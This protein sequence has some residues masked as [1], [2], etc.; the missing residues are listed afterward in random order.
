MRAKEGWE[1]I[2]EKPADILEREIAPGERSYGQQIFSYEH[3][4][5]II[6]F[7]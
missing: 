2:E 7:K 1:Y 5:K 4:G 3:Q 6:S